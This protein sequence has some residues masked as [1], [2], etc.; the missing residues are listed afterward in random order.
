MESKFDGILADTPSKVAR[1]DFK[2]NSICFLAKFFVKTKSRARSNRYSRIDFLLHLA[3]LSFAA[4][5]VE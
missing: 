2:V 3:T 1:I 5:W 4:Q